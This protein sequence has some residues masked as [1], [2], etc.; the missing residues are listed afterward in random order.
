M[1]RYIQASKTLAFDKGLAT[2]FLQ[3]CKKSN[4]PNAEIFTAPKITDWYITGISRKRVQPIVDGFV[5]ALQK[6]GEDIV[7][8]ISVEEMMII[9]L[10]YNIG[11]I[12]K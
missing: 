5:K 4:L 1:K 10:E 11:G 12:T 6:S 9:R 7:F 3:Y 2:R 8:D